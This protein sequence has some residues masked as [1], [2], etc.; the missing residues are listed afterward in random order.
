MLKTVGYTTF[1]EIVAET[2]DLEC[3]FVASGDFWMIPLFEQMQMKELAE[4][5]KDILMLSFEYC[6]RYKAVVGD[7]G[8][9]MKAGVSMEEYSSYYS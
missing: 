2:D 6:R 4:Q 9:V 7:C 5:R 3:W 8:H 1:G